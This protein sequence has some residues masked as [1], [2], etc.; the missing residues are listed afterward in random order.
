MVGQDTESMKQMCKKYNFQNAVI[1]GLD[2]VRDIQIYDLKTSVVERLK[3]LDI[4]VNCAGVNIDGDIEK[5]YPQ[6]L[7]YSIDVNVRANFIIIKNLAKFM[8]EGASIINIGCL[9]GHRPMCGMISGCISKAGLEALTRYAAA[10]LA[11]SNVRVNAIVPCPVESNIMRLLQVDDKELKS[12]RD[13]MQKNIPLGR[14]GKP[15][16]IVKVVAFL[17]SKRSSRIT[18]QIIRVDGGRGLTSSGYVHYMGCRNMNSRFEPDGVNV[19]TWFGGLKKMVI[20]ENLEDTI[21]TGNEKLTQFI[22]DK[23]AESNFSTRDSD[24][25]TSINAIYKKVDDNDDNLKD[26]FLN[27]QQKQRFDDNYNMLKSSAINQGRYTNFSK[28]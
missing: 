22:E 12:F 13:K 15:D 10:E 1:F 27:A 2:L 11:S 6:E 25:H 16:D 26:K 24:A 9:Y 8:N 19:S 17:A 14:I 21:P 3:T 23:I 7:D 28:K 4:I 20:K 18:G 5:T